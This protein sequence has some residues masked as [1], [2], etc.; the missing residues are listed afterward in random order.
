VLLAKIQERRGGNPQVQLIFVEP[1]R[2]DPRFI[3]ITRGGAATGEDEMIPAKTIDE[4]GIRRT[5]EKTPKF[6]PRKEN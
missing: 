2:V 4:S 1:H 6:D 3:V 5:V